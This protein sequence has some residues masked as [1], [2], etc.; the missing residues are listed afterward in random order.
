M[1]PGSC[2]PVPTWTHSTGEYMSQ[3]NYAAAV[4]RALLAAL[5][6]GAL[7]P[8]RVSTVEI[9]HD[10]GCALLAGRGPCDCEPEVG[11]PQLVPDPENN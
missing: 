2:S 10:D 4:E 3:P 5:A 6:D 8:G 7:V 1:R 9:R 11:P